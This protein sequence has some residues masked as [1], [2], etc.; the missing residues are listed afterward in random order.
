MRPLSSKKRIT[1]LT[2][3]TLIFLAGIPLIIL[4]ANGYNLSS[5]YSIIKSGGVY[6]YTPQS[7]SRV[8]VNGVLEKTSSTF[9]R[10]FLIHLR[11]GKYEVSVEKEGYW[12]WG[13]QITVGAGRVVSLRPFMVL[14][15]PV[16]RMIEPATSIAEGNDQEEYL[17]IRSLFESATTTPIPQRKAT[18]LS[19][20]TG[21]TTVKMKGKVKIWNGNGKIYAEWT[22]KPDAVP[23]HFCETEDCFPVV[24]VFNVGEKDAYIDFYPRRDDVIIVAMADGIYAVDIRRGQEKNF[25]PIYRGE[26]LDFRVF[27]GEYLY[28]QGEDFLAEVEEF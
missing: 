1:Y 21:T 10:E 13:Q 6:V 12:S 7:G 24:T 3:F 20:E 25:Q 17:F 11:P 26:N 16:L 15:E 23:E 22:G 2:L 18:E 9:Q 5:G 19:V 4:Y 27:D 28:I 8:Y 14:R